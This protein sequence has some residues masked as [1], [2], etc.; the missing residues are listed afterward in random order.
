MSTKNGIVLKAV[1]V[2]RPTLGNLLIRPL[3]DGEEKSKGGILLPGVAVDSFRRG[4]VVEVG[5]GELTI[6]GTRLPMPAKKGDIV[7]FSECRRVIRVGGEE[8]QFVAHTEIHGV[9]NPKE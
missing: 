6:S 2:I 9:V 5:P 3:D 8:L 4:E 1:D 7:L